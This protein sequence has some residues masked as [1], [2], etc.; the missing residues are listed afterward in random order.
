MPRSP[1]HRSYKELT[2]Q[3]LRSFSETARLG[4]LAAAA[5][6]LG[7][8]HPTVREQV[9]ALQHEFGVTLIEPHGRG[10]RLT[11]EGR[12]LAELAAPIVTSTSAL[13]RRFDLAR[14]QAEVRISIAGTPRF[15]Q[16]DLPAGVEAWLRDRPHVRLTFLELR[17]DQVVPTVASGAADFGLTSLPMPDPLPPG[18][19]AESGYEVETLLITACDHPL[20]RKKRVRPDD[21][22]RYPILSSPYTL[23]D[24]PDLSALLE[25]RGVFDGPSPCVEP[26]FAATLRRY[27]ERNMGIA[28]VYGLLPQD[29]RS[30]LHER[31]M[32]GY[33]GRGLVRFVFRC[34]A[35]AEEQARSLAEAIRKDCRRGRSPGR[36]KS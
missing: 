5:K 14:R 29:R 30:T 17:D 11:N 18:L 25:R 10:S 12:L 20:A 22:K 1:K 27:V 24:E 15:F 9:L 28:L 26:F 6:S 36:V 8:T 19:A 21:L 16:E 35:A 33:F 34:G 3:Q 31:S 23:S 2:F 32:S 13:R 7:L 4:S